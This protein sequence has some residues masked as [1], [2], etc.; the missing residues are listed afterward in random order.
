[1]PYF[2]YGVLL[3]ELLCEIT[4]ALLRFL[5]VFTTDC[6]FVVINFH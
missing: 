4:V 2:W 5:L 6:E 1:M 3:C